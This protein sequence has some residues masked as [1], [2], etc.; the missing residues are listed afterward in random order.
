MPDGRILEYW[1][2]G[3][4][5]G[6]GVIFHP[7]SPVSRVLGRWAHEA[8]VAAQ[9]RLVSVNR[10]GYGGS[11]AT[12]RVPSLLATGRDT[13]ALAAGLGL[14]EYAVV[15]SS[16]GGP[17]AVATAVAD[18]VAVRAVGVVV[19]TGPWRLLNAPSDESIDE[20]GFLALLDAGNVEGALA[21]FRHAAERDLGGL[22]ALN[23]DARI[24]ALI[25]GLGG[26][27]ASD[28]DFRA[29]FA[30][31]LVVVLEN[32]EGFVIDN[33]A[34]GGT[35]DVD[36]S[37]IIA[38]TLLWYGEDDTRCPPVHGQ[39]YRDRIDGSQLV[40]FPGEGHLDVGAGHW[41]EVLAGLLRIW[42]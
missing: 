35:W 25:G 22:K 37:D 1:E 26:R 4:P 33:L 14:A 13:A 11:T 18:P 31:N 29:I 7:G 2:G 8:A 6:P 10:P 40:V 32:L 42:K 30:A 9:V 5:E 36:P 16:G 21:G 39:W 27:L 15:G 24:D 23:G 19:G 41:P 34:W 17:F 20:R 38:P 28:E 3:D 12:T